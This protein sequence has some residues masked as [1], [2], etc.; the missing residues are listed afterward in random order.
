[1]FLSQLSISIKI[2]KIQIKVNFDGLKL[3]KFRITCKEPLE[4]YNLML[5]TTNTTVTTF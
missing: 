3:V 5:K 4:D 2:L 1:L